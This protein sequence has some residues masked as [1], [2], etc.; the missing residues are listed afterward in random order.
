MFQSK[1]NLGPQRAGDSRG[2]NAD[3]LDRLDAKLDD[4]YSSLAGLAHNLQRICGNTRP[5]LGQLDEA[6]SHVNAA[7]AQSLPALL[8]AIG[9]GGQLESRHYQSV[10]GLALQQQANVE[11]VL[12][13]VSSVFAGICAALVAA[14]GHL[15]TVLQKR[16]KLDRPPSG[17][18][19]VPAMQAVWRRAQDVSNQAG[20]LLLLQREREGGPSADQL[21]EALGQFDLLLTM[22]LELADELMLLVR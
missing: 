7:T 6:L 3:P 9:R 21:R 22:S 19:G 17:R 16:A 14:L 11:Q 12:S 13:N 10:H 1:D 2:Q 15:L 4:L 20:S 5:M 18:A 8:R